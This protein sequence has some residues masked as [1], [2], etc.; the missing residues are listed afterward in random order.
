MSADVPID[1]RRLVG[2]KNASKKRGVEPLTS[3]HEGH[4][5]AVTAPDDPMQAPHEPTPGT[6]RDRCCTLVSLES[7]EI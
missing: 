2:V 1:T 5:R 6:R 7:C 4:V 3:R